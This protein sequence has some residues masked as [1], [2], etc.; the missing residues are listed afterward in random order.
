MKLKIPLL[1]AALLAV[2]LLAA[3]TVLGA[4]LVAAAV[5]VA[6]NTLERAN[7]LRAKNVDVIVLD[8]A[9]G[10]A[11]KVLKTLEILKSESSDIDI[12]ARE[13]LRYKSLLIDLIA[14]HTEQPR[15]KVEKDI[16]RDFYMSPEEAQEYGII[17]KVITSKTA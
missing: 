14:K 6:D 10:Q 1:L 11:A 15:E 5:G 17:D 12:V 2:G 9:H 7:E 16:D 13:V 8:T 4:I 3:M